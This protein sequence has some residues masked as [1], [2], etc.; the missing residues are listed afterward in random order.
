M[1]GHSK[2]K[3]IKH[4]KALS[5]AKKGKVFSKITR[6]IAVA[7]RAKGGDPETNPALR[8][9]IDKAR[10]FNMPQENIERAIKKGA[11][12]L[13]GQ[14]FEEF[15]LEAFGPDN[16]ALIIEGTT[17]NKNRTV[18]E[19][20]FLLGQYSGKLANLGSVLWL[21]E[22]CG[23]INITR[24]MAQTKEDLELSAI[25]AGAQDLRWLDEANLEIY[26]KPEEL[27]KVKKALEEKKIAVTAS[28]LDWKPKNEMAI[29]DQKTKG[30]LEKL[31]E[32]LDEN[33]DVN[34]IYS[35]L[36]V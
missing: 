13:A 11:G 15:T 14:K 8:T 7:A 21:F 3:Q 18:S 16:T 30:Q 2:W 35:N 31:L 28:S 23:T 20:K 25:D 9:M 19:I 5:D 29:S 24:G 33:D 27:E 4:K 12:E 26:T 22:R 17:D 6:Q 36:R 32:A 1:S 34:E 10:S